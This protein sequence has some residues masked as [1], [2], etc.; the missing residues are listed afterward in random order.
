[1]SEKPV[2]TCVGVIASDVV[3]IVDS[4]PDP[5][6]RMEAAEIMF[7]GGGPA[8]NAAVTLSRQGVP[9]AVVGRV[10]TDTSGEQTIALLQAEG[11]DTSGVIIDPDVATQTSCIIVNRSAD[12]RSM[13]VTHS[14]VLTDLGAIGAQFVRESQWVHTDHLG[15]AAVTNFVGALPAGPRPLVSL[16]SGNAPIANL[17][18]SKIDLYVPTAESVLALLGGAN[19]EEA[20]ARA[21]AAGTHAIVATDGSRGCFAWWDENGAK[22]AA[23]SSDTS[24]SGHLQVPAYRDGVEVVSTL[25]AGDVFHG[26]L[27]SAL[28]HGANWPDALKRANITAGMSCQGRD[29]RE[30]VPTWPAVDQIM[31]SQ[32]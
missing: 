3:M 23:G 24:G 2:V 29:G 11:V 8:A 15:Y 21:L 17:D 16:D 31:A 22:F 27:L 26:A 4:F 20:A 14:N 9:T 1:V 6:G 25:G 10:G 28:V 7:S 32:A 30:G 12:T 13:I 18:L 5:D 19:L